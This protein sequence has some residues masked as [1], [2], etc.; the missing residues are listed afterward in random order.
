LVIVKIDLDQV[1]LNHILN[2]RTWREAWET[3]FRQIGPDFEWE[4]R[5]EMWH[6]VVQIQGLQG[7]EMLRQE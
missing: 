1:R 7:L 4:R 2:C 3:V 5:Q 6:S